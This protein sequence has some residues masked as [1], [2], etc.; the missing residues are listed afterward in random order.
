MK[1]TIVAI[2][3]YILILLVGYTGGLLDIHTKVWDM[4]FGSDEPVLTKTDEHTE[5][6]A[7]EFQE[8]NKDVKW[9]QAGTKT[10]IKP[11]I[12]F[13]EKASNDFIKE[14]LSSD[15]IKGAKADKSGLTLFTYNN[16]DSTVKEY[17][18]ESPGRSFTLVSTPEGL[19]LIRNNWYWKT[20]MLYGRYE[21][22]VDNIS[23]VEKSRKEIGLKTRIEFQDALEIEPYVMH[24]FNN[25]LSLKNIT[26]GVT[27]NLTLIK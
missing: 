10:E 5:E 4:F 3:V 15:L 16:S 19:T 21:T 13:K 26:V 25:V 22:T 17:N 27:A 24:D 23:L 14:S 9:Y 18:F 11:K 6:R 7:I 1:N 12:I 8:E 20:L 2:A